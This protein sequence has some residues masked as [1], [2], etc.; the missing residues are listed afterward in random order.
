MTVRLGL[1]TVHRVEEMLTPGFEPAFLF[2][3]Y[4]PA[5][6]DDYPLLAAPEFYH[7]E[8]QRLMSS[9]HSWLV[10]VGDNVILIDTGCGN[11]KTREPAAFRRFHMLDT[12]YLERL[13]E[14]GF[15]PEDVTHVI[16]THLHVDH[17]G[18]NTVLQN[19]NWVPTFP[20]AQYLFGE[21]EFANWTTDKR[22]LKIQPEGGPVIED[23]VLPV[24][25]AGLVRFVQAGDMLGDEI[26]FVAAPGHTD[27]QLAV[28]L[29]SQ[30][31]VGLFTAD[32][33]HQPHQVF[34][35]DLNSRFCED[36]QR[37]PVTRRKLLEMACS[38]EAVVFPQHFGAPHC[39]YVRREGADYRFEPLQA[40]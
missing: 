27:G 7:H 39:G 10:L 8:T 32:V 4:D 29:E 13:A 15:R 14:F 12:P 11:G 38:E 36:N 6:L 22:S 3:D 24:V 40:S 5:M 33:L 19:G 9:M 30:G 35:P 20:N 34:R 2:P 28:R 26:K 21:Q 37:A 17:S 25:E 18:W 16:N 31:K 23:S 1:A